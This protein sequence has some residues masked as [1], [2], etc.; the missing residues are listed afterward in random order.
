MGRLYMIICPDCGT[1]FMQKSEDNI[2]CPDCAAKN[3]RESVYR[4]RV[5]RQCGEKFMG[6]PRSFYCESCNMIRKKEQKKR[7]NERQKLGI[8]RKIGSIDICEICGDEYIVNGARQRYC[9]KCNE[10]AYRKNIAKH[11]SEKWASDP[12]VKESRD[13]RRREKKKAPGNISK[14]KC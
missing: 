14:K 5:C 3:K 13:K 7:S 8:T 1:E 11:K 2:V 10:E 4:I 12:T 9:K 6:Y